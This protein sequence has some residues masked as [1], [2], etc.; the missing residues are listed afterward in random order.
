MSLQNLKAN[1]S[2]GLQKLKQQAETK[3]K[4]NDDRFWKVS[5]D[6]EK[7]TGGA[8]I[9][10]LPA[11]QGEE[12]PFVKVYSHGFQG[13]TGKWFG[14]K[15]LS[16]I[17]KRDQLGKLNYLLWNSGV[18]SD[19]A[20]ASKMKRKVEYTTNV[21][22]INDPANPDNNGKVFL[23]KYGPQI[24]EIF[25][26][27]MFPQEGSVDAPLNPFD[28]WEGAD[29]VFRVYG[30]KIPDSRTGKPTIV[31]SYEKSSFKSPSELGTDEKIEE[32]WKHCHPLQPFVAPD[33]FL[34]EEE[35]KKKLFDVLGPTVGSG[36]PV[37]EGWA[38]QSSHSVENR[39]VPKKQVEE[40]DDV[41]DF[42][43]D[44]APAPKRNSAPALVEE[45]NDDDDIAFLKGLL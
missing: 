11:P 34:T 38:H 12:F 39:A 36:I 15:S 32:V 7:G 21:L 24:H 43:V 33:L 29:F 19:K 1:L 23:M 37:V 42:G 4:A 17:G 14:E 9:R 44:D 6:K 25:E 28:P 45:N 18:E 13:P 2:T 10:L 35:F 30:K 16:T 26:T 27:A 22:V 20:V 31:P 3:T 5:F 8:V 41:P 40:F